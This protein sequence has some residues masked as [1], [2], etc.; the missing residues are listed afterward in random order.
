MPSLVQKL[1][2]GADL[3]PE[4]LLEDLTKWVADSK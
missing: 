4:K 3:S 2:Q 1:D